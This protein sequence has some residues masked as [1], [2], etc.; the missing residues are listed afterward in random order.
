MEN[1]CNSASLLAKNDQSLRKSCKKVEERMIKNEIGDGVL[2]CHIWLILSHKT[3][4]LHS[5]MFSFWS[6]FQLIIEQSP[7]SC[8]FK[9]PYPPS[10]TL[11]AP[12]ISHTCSSKG[13]RCIDEG[14]MSERE[15]EREIC[16]GGRERD[17]GRRTSREG[18]SKERSSSLSRLL[19]WWVMHWALFTFLFL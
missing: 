19:E 12:P 4:L 5:K 9:L 6:N 7:D 2:Y 17:R 13:P 3:K 8:D 18:N 1:S 10:P 11:L 15:R 14:Y 16:V